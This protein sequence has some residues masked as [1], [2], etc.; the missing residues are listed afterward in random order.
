MKTWKL[1]FRKITYEF[2]FFIYLNGWQS[3]LDIFT[4]LIMNT[5]HTLNHQ[6]SHHKLN[7]KVHRRKKKLISTCVHIGTIELWLHSD[8]NAMRLWR[9]TTSTRKM[10]KPSDE[11]AAVDHTYGL[12]SRFKW[13]WERI[14][15][16]RSFI[17]SVN[18]N[19][20]DGKCK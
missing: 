8:W 9:C 20:N 12:F 13:S 14:G 4:S 11:S 10:C 15:S 6:A 5:M 17:S 19:K 16:L 2:V 1:K 7:C 3:K 18:R